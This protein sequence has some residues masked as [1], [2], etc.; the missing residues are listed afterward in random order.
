M[1]LM[2]RVTQ[3]CTL[4]DVSCGLAGGAQL[5]TPYSKVHQPGHA[6]TRTQT[7]ARIHHIRSPCGLYRVI[8]KKKNGYPTPIRTHA[9]LRS[10]YTP[11]SSRDPSIFGEKGWGVVRA[12]G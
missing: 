2:S 6:Q 10:R 7:H 8:F 12:C 4:P 3:T 11:L 9:L 1:Q 5:R